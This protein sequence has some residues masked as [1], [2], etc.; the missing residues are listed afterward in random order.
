MA[1]LAPLW[2]VQ[3]LRISVLNICFRVF[4]FA[5]GDQRLFNGLY[6][7]NGDHPDSNGYPHYSN[8]DGRHL[9]TDSP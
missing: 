9:C 6:R 3:A 8:L 4:G 2:R 1:V 7:V 5:D